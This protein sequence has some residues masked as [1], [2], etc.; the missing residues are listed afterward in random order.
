MKSVYLIPVVSLL[1]PA[2]AHAQPEQSLSEQATGD[3]V[4][5]AENAL[6]IGV[7]AG[8]ASGGG[9]IGGGQRYLEDVADPGAAFELDV[10]YRVTPNLVLGG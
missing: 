2:I 10:G 3:Y 9:P 6:E 8:F 7:G 5:P 4:E 1:V